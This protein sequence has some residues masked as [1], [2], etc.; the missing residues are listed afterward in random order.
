MF[1]CVI[2]LRCHGAGGR[3]DLDR[4]LK[5]IGFCGGISMCAF[6]RAAKKTERR[7]QHETRNGPKIQQK[8]HPR[9]TRKNNRKTTK[10]APT[11]LPGGW[12]LE[13]GGVSGA[14]WAPGWPQEGPKS[15][16]G[17]PWEARN[18]MSRAI[19]GA[20]GAT[21]FPGPGSGPLQPDRRAPI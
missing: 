19:W 7:S 3:V 15:G 5:S 13:S 17:G 14:S 16:L 8:R 21:S 2:L 12:F 6:L 18:A 1:S 4:S 11:S 20:K 9:A 10:N